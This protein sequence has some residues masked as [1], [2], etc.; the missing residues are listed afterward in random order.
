MPRVTIRQRPLANGK[1]S[2]LLD[3][4]PPLRD[5]KTGK[6]KRFEF[7]EVY[8]YDKPA[9]K[10]ETK[11]NSETRKLAEVLRAQRQLDIQNRKYGFISD[12]TKDSSFIDFF[13]EYIGKRQKS[14]S[15]NCAMSFRYFVAFAGHDLRFNELTDFLCEDYKHF[16]L[17]GPGISRRGKAITRNTAVNYFAKFRSV[18]KSAYKRGF[19]PIDLYEIVDPI[20]LKETHRERLTI[21]EF[22]L[23]AS[24]PAPS[25][26]IK[27]AAIFSGLTGLRF[28]DVKG[29]KWKDVRGTE[30]KYNLQFIQEKTEGAEV[31]PISD[32]AVELMSQRGEP[33]EFVFK[34]LRYSNLQLFFRKWLAKAGIT[35]NITFH[36]FRHTY[37]T[38]LLDMGVDI[39]TVSK[40]LGHKSIKTTTIYA[41]ISDK[42]KVEASGRIRL[43]LEMV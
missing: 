11:H 7:L 31:L 29:L 27:R 25:D 12:D 20:S 3:Y 15:D 23:L 32:Q 34:N 6:P 17:G 16:M 5:P 39:Y 35:K 33:E 2:I 41:K 4:S 10:L 28:S 24:T 19:I 30:G 14:E 22:Q 42:K 38:L 13:A 26:L 8:T 9:D 18:L 40:M 21:E 37:A 1:H 43:N 36:S